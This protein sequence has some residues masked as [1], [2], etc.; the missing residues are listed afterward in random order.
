MSGLVSLLRTLL[1]G[2]VI[3]LCQFVKILFQFFRRRCDRPP[4]TPLDCIQIDHPAFVRPDPL[5]YSLR[6]LLAQGLAVT[7]DN[8]DITL[9]KGGIPVSSNDLDPA[10]TYEVTARVWNNSLEAPVVG[11]PVHLSFV[12]FGVGNE[13]FPVGSAKVDVGVK[14]S[15]G[16]PAF[17]TIPW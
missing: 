8:P 9:S 12:D 6:A 3:A 16:Q 15:A 11:M 2:W 10:T 4:K 17:V 13:P 1:Y 14:G 7:Y 5:I